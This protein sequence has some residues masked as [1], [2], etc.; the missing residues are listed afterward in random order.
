M[1]FSAKNWKD[2]DAR[3]GAKAF[4]DRWEG[5]GYEKGESQKFWLDLLCNVFGVKDFVN[6]ISFEDQVKLDH[7]SFIDCYIPSTRVLI[8][9][10][11]VE[12]DLRAPSKQSDGRELTPFQQAKRYITELPVSKHPRWVVTCNFAEFLIYDMEK[13][14]GEPEQV[15]LA[16]L[17][18][19]FYRLQFLV[20]STSESVRR[21]E[22]ISLKAGELVGK[23]YDSLLPEFGDKPTD[24]DYHALNVFCVR[25]VFCLYAEDAGI[26]KKEQFFHYLKSF[27]PENMRVALRELFR[28]LDTPMENRDRFMEEK[29]AEFPYVN[30]SLLHEKEGEAIPPIS[31]KT[32][33][34][35]L[36]RASLDFDWSEISPTIFGAVF[37]STLNPETRRSGGMHYTSIEN[38]HKVIDPLFLDDLKNEFREIVPSTSKVLTKAQRQKLLALQDKLG[39]LKFLDPACGSGNFLTETYSSLR[40]LENQILKQLMD[41]KIVMGEIANPVKVDITQFYGIEINDFAVNVAKSAL[42]IAESQMLKETETIVQRDIDFLPLKTNA[43]IVEGN[44]LRMDWTRLGA[45]DSESEALVANKLNIIKVDDLDSLTV[46]DIRLPYEQKKGEITV[47][48]REV[49]YKDPK[50]VDYSAIVNK[51][52]GSNHYDYI[53]GNPP[54]VGARMMK[55][56]SE[57]KK[58]IQDLFGDIKDVQDLDYVTGWY[59]KAAELIMGT[60]TEVAFVSTNSICQG[61]QVPI[62]WKELFEKFGIRINFA[63]QTFK[64]MSES[65]DMAAVHCIVV[66]FANFDRPIKKIYPCNNNPI[67]VQ[68]IS[69]YL[70][71]GPDCFVE[72]QKNPLCDVPKMNFGNQPRDGGNLIVS[73]DDYHEMVKQEPSIVKW[74][75]PYVGADEFINNGKRYCLWLKGIEPETIKK[76][77]I[78]YG[79]VDAV[80]R[81]RLGSKAKTTNGYAKV[82][83]LFAQITQP[84]NVDYLLIPSVSSENRHYI[85]IGFMESDNIS[86]NAVQIIPNAAIYHF[87][88]LTSVVHMAWMRTVAG[89]LEMRYRYSKEIVYNTFPWCKPNEKQKAK[90]E[91]SAKRIL[92][93]RSKYSNSSFASLYDEL[94]MPLDLRKAHAENDK[95]VMEA[96]GFSPKMTEEEIVAKLFKMYQELIKKES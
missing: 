79:R 71:D 15:L 1:R 12:K 73:E 74:L 6:F 24:A 84:D 51:V 43:T 59:Y 50:D 18:R 11:S 49:E 40:K 25:L 55:Q 21:E 76:S 36:N 45:E 27:R 68:N 2:K 44:A 80:R 67:L 38:I 28:V 39:S 9:Q 61:A 54:F 65:T 75:H 70:F 53:M 91:N 88:I 35:L 89:R 92:D 60:Q 3:A 42:W 20:D 95:A 62:L 17:E 19:D 46:N 31:E 93:V 85:P 69:P 56:G 64:W 32:A 23:I 4:A 30:G 37:E 86:S 8:E 33:E 48:T 63:Y 22:E 7:T 5:K 58:E 82:P 34:I 87:G 94:T 72:A 78:L 83:H 47:I 81:F 26:F 16:N 13:P 77:K 57:Q 14:S 10:K 96:Y 29:L 41:D 66:G 52:K 90:I